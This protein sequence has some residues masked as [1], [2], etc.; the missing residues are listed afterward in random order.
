MPD[1][2]S[3]VLHP[4]FRHVTTNHTYG[5]A[6]PVTL[7]YWIDAAGSEGGDGTEDNAFGPVEGLSAVQQKLLEYARIDQCLVHVVGAGTLTYPAEPFDGAPFGGNGRMGIVGEDYEVLATGLTAASGSTLRIVLDSALS[8]GVEQYVGKTIEVLTGAAAGDKRTIRGHVP[9]Y[10]CRV[11]STAALTLSG[12]QTIDGVACVAGDRVLAKNQS[13]GSQNGIWV[14][15]AGAWTR[16]KDADDTVLV[17]DAMTTITAGSVNTGTTWYQ[18]T[19]VVTVGTHAQVWVSGDVVITPSMAFTTSI[20]V[21][22]TFR[23]VEPSASIAAPPDYETFATGFAATRNRFP[24]PASGL[25]IVNLLSHH[26]TIYTSV[27]HFFGFEVTEGFLSFFGDSYGVCGRQGSYADSHDW[28]GQ[29]SITTAWE[30]WGIHVNYDDQFTFYSGFIEGAM[31][32]R[33][34]LRFVYAGERGSMAFQ[35]GRLFGDI[36]NEGADLVLLPVTVPLVLDGC[37]IINS[38]RGTLVANAMVPSI[39]CRDRQAADFTRAAMITCVDLGQ[40]FIKS[41]AAYGWS[42]YRAGLSTTTN[43][44]TCGG[45]ILFQSTLRLLGTDSGDGVTAVDALTISD[46]AVAADFSAAGVSITSTAG[47]FI[48]RCG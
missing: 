27:V 47:D 34:Y 20:L 28:L 5:V 19:A 6:L 22:A 18:T 26:L 17:E 9:K 13:A 24:S 29:P 11:A 12:T 25:Y 43:G 1:L 3:E 38:Q 45:R 7:E 36:I 35:G 4:S 30:G 37:G 41:G 8:G 2:F 46:S 40:A 10:D 14:V 48:T 21:G 23:I 42:A 15:A 32:I 33:A 16:A 39:W 44:T 31:V